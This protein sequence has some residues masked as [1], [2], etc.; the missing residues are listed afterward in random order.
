MSSFPGYGAPMPQRERSPWPWVVVLIVAMGVFGWLYQSLPSG[1]SLPVNGPSGP[2][3][4]SADT[5]LIATAMAPLAWTPEPSATATATRTPA[6]TAT[7][8]PSLADRYGRCTRE[9]EPQSICYQ[10]AS[11]VTPAPVYP[12]CDLTGKTSGLC[13]MPGD[14]AVRAEVETE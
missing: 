13:V 2:S 5:I 9:T 12:A 11:K 6:S 14:E 10:S 8:V 4:P 7:A 1:S 3:G